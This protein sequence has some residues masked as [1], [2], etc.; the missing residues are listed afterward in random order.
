M[1]KN[2]SPAASAAVPEWLGRLGAVGW[3]VLVGAGLVWVGAQLVVRLRLI[4]LP[5]LIALLIAAALHPPAAWLQRRGWPPLLATWTVLLATLGALAGVG[6]L[7]V[8]G[9]AGDLAEVGDALRVAY[10]DVRGWLVDGP[11]GLDA[12]TLDSVEAAVADRFGSGSELIG[13]ATLVLEVGAGVVLAIV[14]AFFYVKDRELMTGALLRAAP[15]RWRARIESAFESG[16]NVLGRYLVGV[17]VVGTADAVLIGIGL[18]LIG[19]PLVVPLM[20][21]TFLGGFFPMV[22]ALLAGAVAALIALATGGLGDALLV[23]ALTTAVQQIDGDVIA[24]LVYSR[25]IDLHPLAIIVALTAGGVVGGVL[26]AFLA[27][28]VVAV[29]VAI[30]RGWNELDEEPSSG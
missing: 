7:I 29:I 25:A 24:P 21:L 1:S 18:A 17:V 26:G 28:P 27:V 22:G 15:D 9:L 14:A 30:R 6:W 12:G 8:P 13:G 23:V 16:W 4:V 2:G 10:E 19:V 3:R 20:V 11:L 5:L